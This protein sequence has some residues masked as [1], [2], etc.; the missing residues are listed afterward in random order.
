MAIFRGIRDGPYLYPV[1]RK[2]GPDGVGTFVKTFQRPTSVAAFVGLAQGVTSAVFADPTG[3][4]PITDTSGKLTNEGARILV[5]LLT[6]DEARL[7]ALFGVNLPGIL[8]KNVSIA[9]I[10][11]ARKGK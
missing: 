6:D 9:S 2:H 8:D 11:R 7:L 3:E 1:S 10:R 5:P 4:Y